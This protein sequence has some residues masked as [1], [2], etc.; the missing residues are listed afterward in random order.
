MFIRQYK[1]KNKKTGKVYIKHQLVLSYR[2][3]AGPRQRII[4]NLGKV[5]LEKSQWRRLAFALEGRLSGQQALMEE[6]DIS[7]AT[8][9]IM[10]NYEF[11][12]IQKKRKE[13][14]GKFLSIALESVGTTACRSLGPELVA[15]DTWKNLSM[16]HI[17][18]AAGLK[19]QNIE[20]A[21]AV[22]TARLLSPGSEAHTQ[23]WIRYG[24]SIAELINTDL[25][26]T[27]KDSVYDISDILLY[28]KDE[29]EKLLREKE[30]ALFPRD[31]TLF[32]YDL[33]NTYFEGFCKG[34]SIAKRGDSKEK[35]S[36]CKLVTLALLVDSQGFPV[37]SQIYEGG[38]SEPITLLDVLDRLEKDVDKTLLT[39]SPTLV[40]D[41][42]IATKDNIALLK[43]RG[44]DYLVVERRKVQ[45]DYLE[46]FAKAKDTFEKIIKKDNTIYFKK[47]KTEDGARLLTLSETKKEKEESMD[48][49][50]ENRFLEDLTN[51]K[52]SIKKGNVRLKEKVG[53]RIG[54]IIERYPTVAKYYDITL[55]LDK[56]QKEA[57][58]IKTSKKKTR[59]DR[60]I[61]TG[62]YVIETTHKDMEAE[63][64]LKSYTMLTRVEKAFQSLKTDLGIRPIY[65]QKAERTRGH[66]F[67]SVLAYHLLNSIEVNLKD[68]GCTK[69]WSTIRRQLSTH[70][71]TIVIMTDRKGGIHHIRVSSTPESSHQEIYNLL[72]IKDPLKR[73][74]LKL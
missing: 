49:L 65:H 35:R 73:I 4:M 67:I 74:H 21:Q 11:Y 18:R 43:K 45:E 2:T 34:N 17:L 66:L 70:M 47:I 23:R 50:K 44:Y 26:N 19:R 36:D 9:Q 71:R 8:A 29:I 37:F 42:G 16:D 46:E 41:K 61:L 14:K 30:A 40:M 24:S 56:S 7:A 60:K 51:L 6:P 32:L 15:Q 28:Y 52:K 63:E 53:R 48:T 57:V 54:R 1:T 3:E 64:I 20:L 62:C 38:K 58:T 68:K 59:D 39:I 22:I 72:D 5:K 12:K 31:S 55:V 69:K 13:S 33:T 10:K 25:L 27:K